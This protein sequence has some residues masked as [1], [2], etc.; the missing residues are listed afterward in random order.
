[1]QLSSHIPRKRFGQNFLRDH[2]VIQSIAAAIAPRPSDHLVE[3][4]PGEGVLTSAL[5]AQAGRLDVVEI[6]RDLVA[7]L[8]RQWGNHERFFLHEADAL[9]FDFGALAPK[10]DASLRVVGN[11]PYN[12]ST[13][14]MFHLFEHAARID[15]MHF[16]L[17]KEV[18]DRI[19]ALPGDSSYGR[20][21]IMTRYHC[22][23]EWLFDVPPHCFYPA[24]KVMSA[25]VRLVPHRTREQAPSS[26]PALV[27]A[28]FNQRRKTLRNSLRQ[29]VTDE[30]WQLAGI[31]PSSRAETLSLED[32]MRLAR[33][34]WQ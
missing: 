34:I 26:F 17:Q 30:Q 1:M 6:D 25:V 12:I 24:P 19:C 32:F 29:L 15:D 18:V 16:M 27:A 9:R 31:D 28:A 22:E 33:V 10:G 8:Q 23:A 2:Q 14:L 21:S 11:L 5:L 3:I 20:L 13:P 7:L 4:G